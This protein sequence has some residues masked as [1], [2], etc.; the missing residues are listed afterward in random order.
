[1]ETKVLFFGQR[2]IVSCD[3]DCEHAWGISWIGE[4]FDTAPDDPG[5]YADADSKPMHPS[6][7]N[8]WCVRECERSTM[9][10]DEDSMG[11]VMSNLP[12]TTISTDIDRR[13]KYFLLG[14]LVECQE[15]SE[16]KRRNP[17]SIP[18]GGW[19]NGSADITLPG[20]VIPYLIELVK[21]DIGK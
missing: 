3:L 14:K 18:L 7:H 2:V 13:W 10:D 9:R 20:N 19:V 5:T 16:K 11:V 21:E 1:M 6:K 12:I 17:A 8:K 15:I 4:K